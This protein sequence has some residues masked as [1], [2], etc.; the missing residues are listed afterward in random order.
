MQILHEN[1]MYFFTNTLF[2]MTCRGNEMRSNRIDDGTMHRA[3]S[4][5][6]MAPTKRKLGRQGTTMNFDL[7]RHLH[8]NG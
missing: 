7:T 1:G 2:P 6:R 5:N 4:V 3:S 8:V